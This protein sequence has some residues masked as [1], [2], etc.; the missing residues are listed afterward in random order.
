MQLN[1][2]DINVYGH[3]LTWV[4][5]FYY[6]VLHPD[7]HINEILRY[8]LISFEIQRIVF[9]FNDKEFYAE[10]NVGLPSQHTKPYQILMS[11]VIITVLRQI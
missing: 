11:M 2:R 1:K 3:V 7:A 8:G 9:V 6:F 4:I 5:G 10:E